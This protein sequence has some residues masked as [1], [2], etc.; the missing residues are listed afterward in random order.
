MTSSAMTDLFGRPLVR[1]SVPAARQI[2]LP[3]PIPSP[4]DE[5][6]RR[7]AVEWHNQRC[8]QT[9]DL[10]PHENKECKS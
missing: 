2:E 8:P 5:Q 9:P 7:D 6:V 1:E 3:F 10:F 4:L